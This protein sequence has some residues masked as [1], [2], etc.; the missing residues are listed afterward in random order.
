MPEG[1]KRSRIEHMPGMR[2]LQPASRSRNDVAAVHGDD[3]IR[4]E[5]LA[6]IASEA[7]RD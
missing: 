1:S 6:D 3:R 2:H 7:L 5:E 4:A